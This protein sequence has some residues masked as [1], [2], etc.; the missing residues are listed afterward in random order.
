MNMLK[1]PKATEAKS[2]A[3]GILQTCLTVLKDVAT[4]VGVPGLGSAVGGLSTII[5]MIQAT[6]ANT[7]R[8]NSLTEYI[9][10]LTTVVE[11]PLSQCR[12]DVSPAMNDRIHRLISAFIL[13]AKD[14]QVMKQRSSLKRFLGSKDGA[15]EIIGFMERIERSIRVFMIEGMFAIEFVSNDHARLSKESSQRIEAKLNEIHG[16]IQRLSIQ[17]QREGFR[18][19]TKAQYN[20]LHRT[21]C[22][23]STRS[24]ILD[25]MGGWISE[26]VQISQSSIRRS[27]TEIFWLNG[28]AGTGKT[29][30]AYTVADVCQRW[31]ILGAS[32]FLLSR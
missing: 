22:L 25:R 19:T 5:D 4:D 27:C 7:E 20:S 26:R 24:E 15:G 12:A 14:M 9:K 11:S 23:A 18:Y 8:V 30:I 2:L 28:F 6:S 1:G 17:S 16:A 21:A 10:N 29:T 31:N 32:F 3:L 13:V